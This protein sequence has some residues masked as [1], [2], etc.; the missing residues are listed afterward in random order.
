MGLSRTM[1]GILTQNDDFYLFKRREV[2]SVEDERPGRVNCVLP[3]LAEQE[4][5][6][7]GKIGRLKLGLQHL[8]PTC[9][10]VWFLDFHDTTIYFSAKIRQ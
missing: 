9:L 5:L 6:K 7:V 3:F 1:I 2:E 10:N 8:I 4:T